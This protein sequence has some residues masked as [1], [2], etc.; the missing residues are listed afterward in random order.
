MKSIIFL[1]TL[2]LAI[3]VLAQTTSVPEPKYVAV[4]SK[5]NV[6]VAIKYGIIRIT[7]DGTVTDLTK[8]SRDLDRQWSNLIIDSKD[9]LYANDGKLIYKFTFRNGQMTGTLFAGQLYSYEL[10]DGPLATAGFNTI[11]TMTLDREDN[12]YVVDSFEKI[13][14]TIGANFVAD[15]FYEAAPAK[16]R[17]HRNY[18]TIRK[19][20]TNGI[21]T[22]LKTGD[23]RYIVPNNVFD[24]AI[25]KDG[26]LLYSSHGRFIGKI[27]LATGKFD[28]LAGQPYKRQYC[29]VYKPGPVASAELFTP[30]NIVIDKV[31]NVI[32][33]DERSYRIVRIADGKVS[34]LAGNN[35]IDPCSQNIGGRA[36]EGNRDGRALTAL[37]YFPKGMAFDSKGNL[38]IADMY[39]HSIR[40]LSPAG[41]VT[42]FAK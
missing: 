25:D 19:I 16:T 1:T 33:A 4:D 29:P 7:P 35:I 15:P 13:K 41:V 17:G 8:G 24:I 40:K 32:V 23:G 11:D 3:P 37:F 20:G 18:R 5:D 12:I 34:T 6:F 2:I 38:Y 14:D 9:N 28:N 22:T 10:K 27:D 36:Q 39:N 26:S 31:G 30:E 21:V 42:T